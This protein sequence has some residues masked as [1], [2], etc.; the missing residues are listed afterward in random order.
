MQ[1]TDRVTLVIEIIRETDISTLMDTA[2][3]IK[4]QL[5]NLTIS[6]RIVHLTIAEVN[7]SVESD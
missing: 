2:G 4:A 1:K 3:F 7:K 5:G 6:N